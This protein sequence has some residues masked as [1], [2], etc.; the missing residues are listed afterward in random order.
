LFPHYTK[1]IGPFPFDKKFRNFRN[2]DKSYGNF[3]GKV[4]ENPE[5]VEFPKSEP[6]NR[7]FWDENQMERKFP[8]KNVRK[9]GPVPHE[10]VLFFGN[11]ANSQ[12]SVSHS[13]NG[14]RATF[15]FLPHFK[16]YC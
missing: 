1:Q 5:I 4:P 11:N 12:I 6:F 15:L 7:N 13:P 14:S 8:G 16:L 3:R 10:V 9:F 2:G